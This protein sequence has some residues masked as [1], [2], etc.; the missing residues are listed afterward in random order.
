[1]KINA[2]PVNQSGRQIQC[3]GCRQ[4]GH[5][6]ADWPN[7]SDIKKQI[8]PPVPPQS[9]AFN[10]RNKKPP[11]AKAQSKP[12]NVKINYISVKAEGEEQAQIYAALDPS[13]RNR[14]FIVLKAEGEYEG[15][16]LTFLIDLG[17]SHSFISPSTAAKRLGLKAQPT[18]KKLRASLANGSSILADEQVLTISFH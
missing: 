5:K 15:N 10:N 8:Q 11:Q 7:K 12:P 1:M 3:F 2:L 14:Q 6:K 13:G 16:S 9:E 17:S 18:G 4:W